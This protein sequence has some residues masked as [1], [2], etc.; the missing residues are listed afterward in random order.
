VIEDEDASARVKCRVLVVVCARL[1]K[2]L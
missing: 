2:K 1:W